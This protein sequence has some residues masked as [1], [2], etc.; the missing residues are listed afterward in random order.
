MSEE[1]EL[2]ESG[3]RTDFHYAGY[4]EFDFEPVKADQVFGDGEILK[5]GDVAITALLTNGHTKGS[6]T[7]VTNVV[8]GGKVYTVV[9][10]NGLSINPGY[11]VAKDP[12][13]PGIQ[14]NYRRT[15]R[16]LET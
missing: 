16:T 3:G 15:L 13:Y 2:L 4:R 14:E 1:K 11:R 12:S 10:P 7:Y 8:D 6:T 5:I 9:F